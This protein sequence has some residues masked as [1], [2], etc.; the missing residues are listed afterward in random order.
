MEVNHVVCT[1]SLVPMTKKMS[2]RAQGKVNQ[3]MHEIPKD[4]AVD[5][6]AY[7]SKRYKMSQTEISNVIEEA[8]LEFFVFPILS[9]F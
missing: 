5:T 6:A 3:T 7:L 9:L 8:A 4:K 1:C 2:F